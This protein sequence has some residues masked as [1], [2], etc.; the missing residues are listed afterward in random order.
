[1]NSTTFLEK[2]RGVFEIKEVK[3]ALDWFERFLLN[4]FHSQGQ[5]DCLSHRCP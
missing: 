1:M 4:Y 2:H 5:L 3:A